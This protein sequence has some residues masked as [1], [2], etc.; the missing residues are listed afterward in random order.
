MK[1]LSYKVER[2]DNVSKQ[3]LVIGG[4]VLFILCFLPFVASG[5]VVDKATLLFIYILLAMMWNLL[6]GFSGLVSVGQQAF[7]GLGGYFALS[8]V[9][10]GMSPYLALLV[11]ALSVGLVAYV[12]SFFVLRLKGGEFAIAMWV[13]AEAIRILVMMDPMVQGETGTS[14]LSMNAYDPELR[15]NLNF[16][17]AL[18]ALAFFG[19]GL[20]WLLNSKIGSAAQAIRD[21]EEAASTIGIRV[22]S[23]QRLIF[24]I[25]A[26]G[27]AVAG[28]LW[29]ANTITFQPRSNFGVQW[30]VF[31]LFMVLVGGL[32]TIEGPIIGAVTFFVLQE[33]FGDFGAWYLAGVGL[34]AVLFALYV[35]NGIWGEVQRRKGVH[36]LRTGAHLIDK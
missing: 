10:S 6:A 24:V 3:T 13:I 33:V 12:M 17:C 32:G 4:L 5:L 7:I 21:D 34:I 28:C 19:G 25:A 30:S 18:V 2:W 35:P 9:E 15:R 31:M 23:I 26:M 8:L 14:L 1:L 11:G 29:L 22:A 20:V 16:W 27:C 36:L